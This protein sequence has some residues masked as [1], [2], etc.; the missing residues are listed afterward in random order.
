MVL[1]FSSLW[2]SAVFSAPIPFWLFLF[3]LSVGT[4]TAIELYRYWKI[5]SDLREQNN[6]L[7]SQCK[8]AEA[9]QKALEA[10]KET[11][12]AGN[13]DLRAEKNRLEQQIAEFT[14]SGPRLHGVWNNSQTF[15]HMGH[16]GTE[17]V[18]QI[19]GRIHLTSSNTDEVLHLLAGYIEGQ[20][21]DLFEPV[22]VRPD[23][24]EDEEVVLYI[25]PPF[26]A[27]VTRSFTATIVL[28]D[29]QNRL[30]ML[31]RH[32]F[33]PTEQAPPWPSKDL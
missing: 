17:R 25:S 2:L 31:P 22:S 14:S 21:L 9:L 3:V 29:H 24:I 28:E 5:S 26:E 11:L 6:T 12:E 20:R 18:M 15:W 19:G 30:H 13:Q 4:F 27:D 23:L 8:N 33:R 10:A 1:S 32:S 16:N 7:K